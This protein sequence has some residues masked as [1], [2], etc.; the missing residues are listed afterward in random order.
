MKLNLTTIGRSLLA[1]LVLLIALF[2]FSAYKAKT[3]SDE[4]WKTLGISKQSGMNNIKSSFMYGY[5]QHYGARNIKNIAVG[6]RAAVAKDLLEFTKSYVQGSEFKQHYE[7][8]RKLS[9]PEAPNKKPLRSIEEIQKEEIAKTEKSI[10]DTEKSM[11][12]LGGEIAK[13]LKPLVDQM[14]QTLKDYQNPNHDTFRY[15]AMGEK[16]Q[17]EDAEKR[18]QE[19]LKRWKQDFPENINLFIADK[20]KKM[21]LETEGIDYNGQL[22]EKYGKK[23]FV[24]PAYEGKGTSW[25]QGFRAGKE[26]TEMARSFAKEWL[27][28][29]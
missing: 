9:M 8:E 29:L 18:Y 16:M 13:S 5:L 26:V 6:N 23:R 3:A 15:I 12:E 2:G 24:N 1:S 4:I 21:L 22:V 17:Q 11:K 25:K 20:L 19:D 28:E 7:K 27:G 14:K 10:R